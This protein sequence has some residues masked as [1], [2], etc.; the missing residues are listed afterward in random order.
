MS[1]VQQLIREHALLVDQ[2]WRA[3][4]PAALR[5]LAA[6][7]AL[8]G[9]DLPPTEVPLGDLGDLTLLLSEHD[10]RS[11]RPWPDQRHDRDQR[12]AGRLRTRGL[13]VATAAAVLAVALVA[14]YVVLHGGNEQ[15][16][17]ST[18]GS[19][20]FGGWTVTAPLPLDGATLSGVDRPVVWTGEEFLLPG[21]LAATSLD[22]AALFGESV[23]YRP[24]GGGWRHVSAPPVDLTDRAQAVWTGTELVVLGTSLADFD[25]NGAQI[26]GAAY[27]PFADHWRTITP[28]PPGLSLTGPARV[29]FSNPMPMDDGI[30]H[31]QTN[32]GPTIV[33]WSPGQAVVTYDPKADTWD[34]RTG[35]GHAPDISGELS[36]TMADGR[37]FV[38]SSDGSQVANFNPVSHG[39]AA[40]PAVPFAPTELFGIG[41]REIAFDRTS[42][43]IAV[44]DSGATS[45]RVGDSLP[46][47]GDRRAVAVSSGRLVVWGGTGSTHRN[48]FAYDPIHD[49]WTAI[50]D[51][52]IDPR[53]SLTSGTAG[54]SWGA[55]TGN[56][57]LLFGVGCTCDSGGHARS[58]VAA[59]IDQ[60]AVRYA[61]VS[62]DPVRP[63]SPPVVLSPTTTAGDTTTT[64]PLA[65][66]DGAGFCTTGGG[67]GWEASEGWVPPEDPTPEDALRRVLDENA[68]SPALPLD[69]YTFSAAS[70]DPRYVHHADDG[71][72]D[73]TYYLRLLD[74]GNW[75]IYSGWNCG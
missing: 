47:V 43:R 48:G 56:P 39:W 50:P 32:D 58:I 20:R 19:G 59:T 7:A 64:G 68:S 38:A 13:V 62:D 42:G 60:R 67:G 11:D 21:A 57:A 54:G 34:T 46:E 66:P 2:Q 15:G 75:T 8:A 25:S 61:G 55:P 6:V 26:E 45:W 22:G 14:S 16:E 24:D 30:G 49:T 37:L 29:S 70:G 9:T 35:S 69:G 17:T 71:S 18:V 3:L 10:G 51:L 31:M 12:S 33:M 41:N 27:D 5:D 72:V 4:D 36:A 28:S 23:A 1:E 65:G 44:L 53:T 52:P 40:T 73:A 74:D 63:D